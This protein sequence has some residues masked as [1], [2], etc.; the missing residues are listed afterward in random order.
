[1][2][3]IRLL[4][5]L[6]LGVALSTTVPNA[7]AVTIT[8]VNGDSPFEGL[9]DPT[10][11]ISA[12]SGT[13]TSLG[14]L[15]LQALRHA[16][17]LWS[18]QLGGIG[19]I[20]ILAKFDPLIC[21]P[22]GTT[23]A[24]SGITQLAVNFPGAPL[25]DTSYPIALANVL[26]GVDLN[27]TTVPEMRVT[28]NSSIDQGC[29]LPGSGFWYGID[30]ASPDPLRFSAFST[31]LHEIAHG[32]GFTLNYNVGRGGWITPVGFPRGIPDVFSRKTYDL[33]ISGGTLVSEMSPAQIQGIV[34][35]ASR[36]LVWVGR[37]VYAFQSRYLT[38][39]MQLTIWPPSRAAGNYDTRTLS[40]GG[41]PLAS[42]ERGYIVAA[43]DEANPQ[44]P[45]TLDA[46]SALTNRSE[47]FGRIVIVNR[48]GCIVITKVRNAQAA[49]AVAVL[50]QNTD[51]QLSL[52]GTSVDDPR[53]VIPSF[54]IYQSTG[55]L[56]RQ[57]LARGVMIDATVTQ[58][59]RSSEFAGTSGTFLRMDPRS[60]SHFSFDASPGLLM[61]PFFT[62][63]MFDQLDLTPELL[64]DIGWPRPE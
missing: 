54:S 37:N 12:S 56:I 43:L 42:G 6:F 50:I 24:E 31:A 9:N 22:S 32:L 2:N 60:L 41:S 48:G 29:Y 47:V 57:E 16:A 53:V 55:E 23:L 61:Q 38:D 8:V 64:Y 26:A 14:A 1:M 15:R 18:R 46:C 11:I 35:G 17:L 5:S 7:Y 3:P 10:P 51:E 62:A 20:K 13:T 63:G 45:S 40:I 30:R 52:P 49:G 39:P 36:H 21:G 28:F 59:T 33:S 58:N 27:G 44:G 25:R 4:C 34:N 19:E